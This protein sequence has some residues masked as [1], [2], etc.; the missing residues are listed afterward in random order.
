MALQDLTRP[1]QRLL[2]RQPFNRRWD[3]KGKESRFKACAK[4]V[5]E[6]N[7]LCSPTGSEKGA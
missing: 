6:A 4:G 3:L 1:W 7:Q 5:L 2:S